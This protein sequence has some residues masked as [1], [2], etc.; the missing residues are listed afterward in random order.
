MIPLDKDDDGQYCVSGDYSSEPPG[1]GGVKTV[2]R[3]FLKEYFGSKGGISGSELL[4]AAI[5]VL[6]KE[7]ANIENIMR[8]YEVIIKQLRLFAANGRLRREAANKSGLETITVEQCTIRTEELAKPAETTGAGSL[9][10]RG[11]WLRSIAPETPRRYDFKILY[12]YYRTKGRAADLSK[13]LKEEQRREKRTS[14]LV[15]TPHIGMVRKTRQLTKA[16]RLGGLS[17]VK[18]KTKKN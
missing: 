3:K 12:Y 16:G 9:A 18:F 17:I 15:V 14:S 5:A 6:G 8:L 7:E 2:S 10:R 11:H 1:R 4:C 13:I